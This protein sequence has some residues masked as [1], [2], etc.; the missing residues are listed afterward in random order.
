MPASLVSLPIAWQFTS[1]RFSSS[2]GTRVMFAQS[3]TPPW[4]VSTTAPP[5][6]S[7]KYS[8]GSISA[9]GHSKYR[10]IWDMA[11]AVHPQT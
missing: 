11:V 4:V 8:R 6:T 1:E 9:F 10:M 5:S 2:A 3:Y 7:Q